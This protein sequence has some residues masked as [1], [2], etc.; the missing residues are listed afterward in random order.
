MMAGVGGGGGVDCF[1][2]VENDILSP[3]RHS[4]AYEHIKSRGDKREKQKLKN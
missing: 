1:P 4:L 2:E 3:T